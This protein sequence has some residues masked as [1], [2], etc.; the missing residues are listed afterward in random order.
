[1]WAVG[2]ITRVWILRFVFGHP[3]PAYSHM[4][5]SLSSQYDFKLVLLYDMGLTVLWREGMVAWQILGNEDGL[6]WVGGALVPLA[7]WHLW[8]E[9]RWLWRNTVLCVLRH[10]R[11]HRP[12]PIPLTGWLVAM[13]D[14]IPESLCLGESSCHSLP[15][16]ASGEMTV[17][18]C[19][20]V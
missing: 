15:R 11:H 10:H 20:S 17:H 2:S 13:G 14:S 18:G 7:G 4:S 9:S 1:M 3:S 12:P 6:G 19:V 16:K 5:L 8:R